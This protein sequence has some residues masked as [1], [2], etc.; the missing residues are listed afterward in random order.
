LAAATGDLILYTDADLPCDL[1]EAIKACRLLRLYHADVVSA[2]RRD[3]TAEGP[4]RAIYSLAYNRLVAGAFGLRLRDVNFAF[5]L[6]RREVLDAVVLESEGSFVDAELLVRA[7][8]AGFRVVQFGVDFFPRTRGVSTLSSFAT[9]RTIVREMVELRQRLGAVPQ[10][11]VGGGAGQLLIVNADDYGLTEG[12]SRG[13]LHAHKEGIVTSTSVLALAPAL[14][15]C[16]D[17]LR[18]YP[19]L[20]AASEI[21]TLVDRKGRLPIDWRRFVV[22]ARR[23][24]IDPD[25]LVR[26]LTA[27]MER[28]A[29]FGVPIDHVDTH[30]HLHLW[31]VV[32]EAVVEVAQRW[33]VSG[34]RAPRSK[35]KGP[36][37]LGVR[38]LS[39]RLVTVADRCGLA[40]PVGSAGL[41]EAGAVDLATLV[42]TIDRLAASGMSTLELGVH[43][44]ESDD[45]DRDRYRWG[46]RWADEL[47]ALTDPAALAAV[48]RAGVVLG[49]YADLAG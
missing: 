10:Q 29:A 44:G 16:G 23:G 1:N 5:K 45:P 28:V 18:D 37:G 48:T 15:V 32:R 36:V 8:R 24:A 14:Q 21:P 41:D 17:W 4:R 20:L 43:P 42:A 33:E 30:Q 46:Y 25:D 22:R 13:I 35:R 49:T 26:E 31:P 6:I 12:V 3:R 27:Q 47:A 9:I 38:Q 7:Q 19:P 2:W 40:T 34:I 11:R 39:S